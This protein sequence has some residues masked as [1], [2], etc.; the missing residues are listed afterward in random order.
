MIDGTQLDEQRIS[1]AMLPIPEEVLAALEATGHRIERT[2]RQEY[3]DLDD[4]QRL[5]VP[6]EETVVQPVSLYEY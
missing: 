6:V 4:G 3:F 2:Y 5:L 1:L